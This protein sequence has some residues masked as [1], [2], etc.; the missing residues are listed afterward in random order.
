MATFTTPSTWASGT[1][2]TETFLDTQI[3][4]NMQYMGTT[5]RHSTGT[6]GEGAGYLG[7][8]SYLDNKG[9]AVPTAPA[10][11]TI[12]RVYA[13]ATSLGWRA[14]NSSTYYF[15][16]TLHE[17]SI[18]TGTTT[19]VPMPAASSTA[20]GGY[21]VNTLKVAGGNN[22]ATASTATFSTAITVGGSG[23][24]A[25]AVVGGGFTMVINP[26]TSKV[27]VEVQKDGVIQSTSE[28]YA[29]DTG[30]TSSGSDMFHSFIATNQASGSVTW[31][32]TQRMTT[33]TGTSSRSRLGQFLTIRELKQQ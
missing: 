19:D 20:S 8:I 15:G 27:R 1:I 11:S 33:L 4:G 25:L 18:G 12:A 22:L 31:G 7:P 29:A 26:G 5:H 32:V 13:T 28:R 21:N 14:S 23:S 3:F 9:A 2:V 16:D 17:H 30:G 6:A 10:N 24:R